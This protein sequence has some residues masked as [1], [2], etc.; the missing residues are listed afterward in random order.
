MQRINIALKIHFALL[1]ALGG[2]ILG[3]GEAAGAL[4]LIAIFSALFS[5]VFIDLLGL[6][7]LPSLAAYIGMGLVA[8]YCI[9]D[10]VPLDPTNNRQLTAVAQ[11]LVLVQAVLMLQKKTRRVF[12]QIGVFCM[13]ELVVAAVFNN[14]LIYAGLLIPV[15]L[16]GLSALVLLQVATVVE[17][18]MGTD[19][20]QQTG[21]SGVGPFNWNRRERDG[22]ICTTAAGSVASLASAGRR[23]PRSIL[24]TAAFPILLV[25]CVFFYAL[26]RTAE[27][28]SSVLGVTPVVGFSDEIELN[29]IGHLQQSS[30]PV[31][32]VQLT[33]AK[34]KLPYPLVGSLYLRGAVLENYDLESG[35]GRWRGST[36]AGGRQQKTLPPQFQPERA[37]D[38]LF[39]DEVDVEITIQPQ[40]TA[41]LFGIAP[42]HRVETGEVAHAAESWTIQRQGNGVDIMYPRIT[43]RFGTHAFFNGSQ[44]DLIRDVPA[45]KRYPRRAEYLRVSRAF[46]NP[47]RREEALLR[48]DAER[49]P[50][51]KSIADTLVAEMP[52]SER[53]PH[54]IA[55]RFRQYLRFEADLEYTLDLTMKRDPHL[56]PME[57]FLRLDRRGHCQYFASTL[58]MMLRSQGIPARLVVGYKSDEFSPYGKRYIIRQLHAHAWVE[59]LLQEDELPEDEVL[60]GQPD[61]G[62]V[63]AR[64]DPTPSGEREMATMATPLVHRL[65]YL[66]SLWEKWVLDMD[67]KRQDD[68]MLD[69]KAIGGTDGTY[70]RM[71]QW[72]KEQWDG[73]RFAEWDGE[74]LANRSLFS[75][76]AAAFGVL[77]TLAV[78]TLY[79]VG[80]T[81]PGS[82]FRRRSEKTPARAY[83]LSVPFFMQTCEQLKRIGVERRPAETAAEFTRLAT[84]RFS[85]DVVANGMERSSNPSLL[86]PSQPVESALAA[87]T[88]AYYRAR[89]GGEASEQVEDDGI[90]QALRDVEKAVDRQLAKAGRPESPE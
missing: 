43:Y 72:L 34:S 41:S 29:Q 59:A 67:A 37:T 38:M 4:P 19:A 74:T 27:S 69:A 23:L 13:L 64:L 58:A 82:L 12:E 1:A 40:S 25:A 60:Y 48:F 50:T 22:N 7:A 86:S 80:L 3:F 55:N 46:R 78:L 9:S 15:S 49:L 24:W 16:L 39:Y 18:A 62:P 79:R 30:T 21:F 17:P 14:A 36:V 10:F 53:G 26:P 77:G 42:Y 57:Q 11:L 2:V 65:D 73:A 76:P 5:L 83:R 84:H 51:I 75:W 28:D 54:R 63:W 20:D 90:R 71:F 6:F 32:R 68:S 61:S 44:T 8:A 81:T 89:F 31:M 88:D 33:N 35:S 87:I 66:Q 52:A 70:T 45:D 47:R 85:E 56:D